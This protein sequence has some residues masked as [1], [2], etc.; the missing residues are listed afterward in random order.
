MRIISPYITLYNA[1]KH[2]KKLYKILITRCKKIVFLYS[3][4]FLFIHFLRKTTYNSIC[5]ILMLCILYIY[6]SIIIYIYM[7][8]NN[9]QN[10]KIANYR[11]FLLISILKYFLK[12]FLRYLII[13]IYKIYKNKI[14]KEVSVIHFKLVKYSRWENSSNLKTLNLIDDIIVYDII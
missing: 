14:M 1:F 12:N 10:Y 4:F 2:D 7:K 8:D 3:M 9:W 13:F 5:D 6:S 11:E